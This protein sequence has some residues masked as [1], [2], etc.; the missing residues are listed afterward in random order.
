MIEIP[1]YKIK[2]ITLLSVEE[3]E[4]LPEAIRVFRYWWWLKQPGTEGATAACVSRKGQV[5]SDGIYVSDEWTG[6]RPALICDDLQSLNLK[7]GDQIKALGKEWQYI[8]DD[9]VL[10]YGEPLIMMA[11]RRDSEAPDANV[12]DKSDVKKYLFNWFNQDVFDSFQ[13]GLYTITFYSGK[14]PIKNLYI[15]DKEELQNLIYGELSQNSDDYDYIGI[16]NEGNHKYIEIDIDDLKE[17]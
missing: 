13:I 14:L 16:W 3:A 8:G 6:V 10:L 9:M 15:S 7:I 4:K 1:W 12:Y 5:R 11:F 17:Q 2:G